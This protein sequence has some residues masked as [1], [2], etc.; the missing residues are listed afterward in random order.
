MLWKKLN[1][2]AV[3]RARAEQVSS[4]DLTSLENNHL[5]RKRSE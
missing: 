1:E 3:T 2:A 4:G 5:I